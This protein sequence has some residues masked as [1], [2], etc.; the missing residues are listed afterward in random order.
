[1]GY[2]REFGAMMQNI[3]QRINRCFYMV[4]HTQIFTETQTLHMIDRCT[5]TQICTAT[6][7]VKDTTAGK[8]HLHIT[9]TVI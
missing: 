8:N 4:K 5:A 6:I 2:S 1:M 3:I 7:Y 9:I